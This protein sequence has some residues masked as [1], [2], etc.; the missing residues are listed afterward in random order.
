MPKILIFD[1]EK[2]IREMIKFS[3]EMKGMECFEASSAKNAIS[4]IYANR[5]DLIIL[6]WMMPDV[7]G[8]EFL[9]RIKRDPKVNDIPV[10]LLT[11]KVDENNVVTGL[12][13]GA[14]DYIKKPFS[15]KELIARINSILRRNNK[16]DLIEVMLLKLDCNS[17]LVYVDNKSVNLGPTEFKLLKFLIE[18]KE[19]TFTREQILDRVWGANVYIDERTVDVHIRRIRKSLSII[20]ID[21]NSLHPSD[22]IQ[23]VRGLGYRLSSK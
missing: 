5:P 9:R 17:R 20:K 14:E 1:D 2:S 13:A 15:T 8:I 23:T 4:E 16:S 6:D 21:T 10:I 18:N 7:S 3:L 19:K 11:A 22:Y 12:D